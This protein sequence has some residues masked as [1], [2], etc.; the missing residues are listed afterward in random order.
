MRINLLIFCTTLASLACWPGLLPAFGWLMCAGLLVW[1]AV[2]LARRRA[3]VATHW[4]CRLAALLL[5]LLLADWHGQRH[6]ANLLP[7]DCAGQRLLLDGSVIDLPHTQVTPRGQVT[8]LAF[9][10]EAATLG[11]GRGRCDPSGFLV[12]RQV[13][14]SWYGAPPIV[15]GERWQLRAKLRRPRGLVNPHGG[16]Y[17]LLLMRQGWSATGSVQAGRRLVSARASFDNR[18]DRWRGFVDTHLNSPDQAAMLTALSVGERRGLSD[19]VQQLLRVTGTAHLLAIS[20]LHVGM[21][22]LAGFVLGRVCLSAGVLGVP[23][24][25]RPY[26]SGRGLAMCMSLLFAC[27]YAA[28]SGFALST[29]RALLMVVL[30]HVARCL[31]WR[32]SLW[33]LWLLSLL[34]VLLADPLHATDPGFYLSFGAVAVLLLALGGRRYLGPAWRRR[35][36]QAWVPQWW[37]FVG[38]LPLSVA[39][40]GGVSL[41]SVLANTV[42][43]PW[44]TLTSVP[45]LLLAFVVEPQA[46]VAAAWLLQ[47]A[48]QSIELLL[49]FL[50]WLS[51][52]WIAQGW[53]AVAASPY[54]GAL[55]LSACLLVLLPGPLALRTAGLASV[56][57]LAL[58]YGVLLNHSFSPVRKITLFDVGQGLALLVEV[59]GKRLLYDTGPPLGERM[60]AADT[61]ILPYLQAQGIHRLDVL[62]ISHND[63]DHAGGVRALLRA[64]AVGEVYAGEAP[65]LRARFQVPLSKAS[66]SATG[67]APVRRAQNCHASIKPQYLAPDAS[68]HFLPAGATGSG[69]NA[70]CVLILDFPALRLVLPGDIDQVR[71]LHLVPSLHQVAA[72]P[73]HTLLVAPHHGSQSSSSFGLL[74]ALQWPAVWVSAGYASRY[75]H[76]HAGV[77][78]KYWQ[79]DLAVQNTARA[80]AIQL[81]WQPGQPVQVRTWRN[82]GKRF[83]FE[84]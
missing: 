54:Q 18:R 33:D 42:A 69:N 61:A 10:V 30:L 1:I 26:V 24:A 25:W 83:W 81:Y 67:L 32:W 23:E 17:Q 57:V 41:V 38:L 66:T 40:F 46:P 75:G 39:L 7:A 63:V 50:T 52:S 28:L 59:D 6:V 72:S 56:G 62:V 48:A 21:L 37:V 45:P 78:N 2:D 80:G 84:R 53:W 74:G 27:T 35:F 3:P 22:A 12:G 4:C 60:T 65:A 11:S 71:E 36:R 47:L 55:L 49:G 51:G 14:L 76:P 31:W 13:K 58:A 15:A 5:G 77:L 29:Q 79:L 82:Y 20:G 8:G 73:K 9:L 34:G 19:T 16:D 68:F 44:V 64:V 70:S 43:I